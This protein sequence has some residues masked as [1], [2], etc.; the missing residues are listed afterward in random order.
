MLVFS[1]SLGNTTV[2]RVDPSTWKIAW[3][4][5]M[6]SRGHAIATDGKYVYVP[7]ES[8][9]GR[10]V[11]LDARGDQRG[12]ITLDQTDW[13]N[14]GR[15]QT[16]YSTVFNER[17]KTLAVAV[18]GVNRVFL[19]DVSN[20]TAPALRGTIP[21]LGNLA[22]AGT[23]LW[24]SESSEIHC[25]DISAPASPKLMGTHSTAGA[26]VVTSY[27]QVSANRAGTRLYALYQAASVDGHSTSAGT[28]AGLAAF[29]SSGSTPGLLQTN[30]W[31]LPA[32]SA[33]PT[34]LAVSSKD[35]VAVTYFW[36]GVRL[37][38]VAGDNIVPLSVVQTAGE[39]RDVYVDAQGYIY[40]FGDYLIGAYDPSGNRLTTYYDGPYHEGG[41]IRFKDG[42]V[43]CPGGWA[44]N[45]GITGWAL[46]GGTIARK[47]FFWDDEH[48]WALAFDGTYL[49][50]GG[51][52][53]VVVYSVGSAADGYRL[54]QIGAL[55]IP[56]A[57]GNTS[58]V[59]RAIGLHGSVLW[60][61]GD[62]CGVVAVDVSTP[63][64]P[65]LLRQDSFS[66]ATNGGHCAVVAAR[67]RIYVGCGSASVRI[68]NPA[69]M[70]ASGSIPGYFATFLDKVNDDLLVL[71]H[72]GDG[73]QRFDN[74]GVYLF[75]L[76]RNPDSPTLFARAPDDS[77]PNFRARYLNGAIY[78]C[79]LW[80]V[81]K[82]AIAG[83]P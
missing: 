22:T 18:A 62:K 61:T 31:K 46:S 5:R 33:V 76:R 24:V 25:W 48:S 73:I 68:Y 50:Q 53:G 52:T 11:V 34:A 79:P 17:V 77:S 40:S 35:V 8:N 56:G 39:S 70:A 45:Q 9:P 30:E 6:P 14:G 78:R 75:D 29:D 28:S 80:G 58:A 4:Q 83:Y 3:T 60:G 42:L 43:L 38:A 20:P 12:G 10:V 71:S 49:Y 26:R 81:E 72:Y 44:G 1:T 69:T 2:S 16:I 19:F 15:A 37:H 47:S 67:N 13:S 51:T 74:E 54:T 59:V 36:F 27:G 82:L 23:K 55:A 41:W 21:S 64:S 7:L 32:Q 63:Q 66:Y 57:A 65:R